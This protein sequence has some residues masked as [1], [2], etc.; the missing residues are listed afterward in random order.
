MFITG[1]N[2]DVSFARPFA[3]AQPHPQS[4]IYIAICEDI[5]A[6]CTHA[7]MH[8]IPVRLIVNKN[9][10][11]LPLSL[12]KEYNNCWLAQSLITAP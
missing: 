6:A 5:D 10:H 4:T 2:V 1:H 9:S 11:L 7:G 8:H 12:R 3:I